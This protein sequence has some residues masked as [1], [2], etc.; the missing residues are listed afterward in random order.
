VAVIPTERSDAVDRMQGCLLLGAVGDAFGYVVEFLDIDAIE[1]RC[2]GRHRF[3]EPRKWT[4]DGLGHVVS[5]DT[6]MT[7]FTAQACAEAL[8]DGGDMRASLRLR[9]RGCYLDWYETQTGRRR[10]GASALLSYQEMYARRAPG[11]TCL[12]ALARGANGSTDL[13]INDSK[14]CG[15]IMRVAPVGFLPDIDDDTAWDLGCDTA[16]LTHGHP[17]GWASA[18]AMVILVRRIAAGFSPR[19]AAADLVG[20]VSARRGLEE[21]AVILR[22]S[23]TFAGRNS[24]SPAEMESLGGG[25]IAEECLAIGL[26]AALMDAD[27]GTMLEVAANHSGDSDSTA[28]VTGNLIGTMLGRSS[29]EADKYLLE[30]FRDLDIARP[31]HEVMAGYGSAI[32]LREG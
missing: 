29:L 4:Y 25:W 16:A 23:L 12:S 2:G 1:S 7:M 5:D 10:P 18:G 21:L 17:L 9:A 15:G 22:R 32:A 31:M 30:R 3:D 28:V 24:I 27:I 20:Y 11:N 26:A 14:G 13:P 8:E 6:Q 19:E